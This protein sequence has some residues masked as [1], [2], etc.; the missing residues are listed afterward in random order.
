[1]RSI[2]VLTTQPNTTHNTNEIQLGPYAAIPYGG[3]GYVIER[4]GS[5]LKFKSFVVFFIWVQTKMSCIVRH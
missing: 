5:S 4:I 3:G 2:T 1:M